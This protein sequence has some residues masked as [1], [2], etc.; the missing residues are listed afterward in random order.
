MASSAMLRRVG[1]VRTDISEER[2]A[3][4]I[5]VTRIGVLGTLSVTSDGRPCLWCLM[6]SLGCVSREVGP[7]PAT[8]KGIMRRECKK[9]KTK[10][11]VGGKTK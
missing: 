4:I 8:K 1:L 9:Q 2:S 7:S 3:S 11:Y 10:E 5:R 6:A